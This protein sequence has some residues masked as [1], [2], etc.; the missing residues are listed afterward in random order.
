MRKAKAEEFDLIFDI[1]KSSFPKDEYRDYVAQKQLLSHP[2]YDIY[3]WE[4]S[5]KICAFISVWKF[6]NMVFIEHFAVAKS[7]RNCGLGS[8]MLCKLKE[9]LGVRLC[10]EVELPETNL[11]RRRVEFYKRNG[12]YYN[13]Y[14][15]EQPAY[16]KDQNAVPLRI[17]STMTSLTED[18]FKDIKKQIYKMVYQK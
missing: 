16:S 6:K 15:Y 11:A 2:D 7:C 18:E 9:T 1:M 10:L 4:Q 12:F 3:V 5:E 14:M 13:D 8:K 17:M